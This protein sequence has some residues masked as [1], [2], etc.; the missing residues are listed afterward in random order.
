[1]ATPSEK[2]SKL[3]G[4]PVAINLKPGES[5]EQAEARVLKEHPQDFGGG[6]G[7]EDL[8][9]EIKPDAKQINPLV[10]DTAQKAL[11]FP[12]GSIQKS[13]E[14]TAAKSLEDILGTE[15]PKKLLS[16]VTA[17]DLANAIEGQKQL[18][19]AILLKSQGFN[20]KGIDTGPLVG[21]KIP[22]TDQTF[23]PMGLNEWYNKNLGDEG[24]ASADRSVLSQALLN[25]LNPQRKAITGASATTGELQDYIFPTLPNMSDN[26]IAFY[27][28]AIESYKGSQEKLRNIFDTLQ[29]S[30]SG[31]VSGFKD[32]YKKSG[33]DV[34]NELLDELTQGYQ[35]DEKGNIKGISDYDIGAIL[36]DTTKEYLKK[37]KP[38]FKKMSDEELLN[39]L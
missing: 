27:K 8:V 35:L 30:G 38:D 21:G 6:G 10:A 3:A 18:K 28:K 12:S 24:E 17:E 14:L 15:A 13:R 36:P 25:V 7:N 32:I 11:N 9:G 19:K 23:L 37:K 2:L 22:F 20:R 39:S 1:M 33:D 34:L 5:L 16:S 31:D 26:D 29:R 4:K